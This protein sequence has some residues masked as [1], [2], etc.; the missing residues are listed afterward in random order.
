MKHMIRYLKSG[1][2][3][4]LLS[5]STLTLAGSEHA[6][7]HWGYVDGTGPAHWGDMKHEFSTCKTGKHQSP[8]NISATH[9]AS[10]PTIRFSYKA[11][12]LNVVNNGHTIQV[13]YAPGSHITVAGKQYEL[14]QFHFHSPSEHEINGKPADM[15]AHLVHKAADGQLAVVAVLM[16]KGAS[17]PLI[18][19]IWKHMPS[20]KGEY[21]KAAIKINVSDLLPKDKAYYHYSGSLTTPPCSEGVNWMLLKNKVDVAPAQVAAFIDIFPK[22]TRPVQPLNGRTIEVSH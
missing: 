2:I 11:T 18:E 1:L 16:K 19:K 6:G 5:F 22:S 7:A 4:L 17:N 14:L 3:L 13:N 21:S 9:N 20:H 12:P 8:I 15:V 10:L